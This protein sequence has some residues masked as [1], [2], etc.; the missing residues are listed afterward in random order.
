MSVE[1][2]H[3]SPIPAR[4]T[5][6]GSVP[7]PILVVVTLLGIEGLGNLLSIP[8]NT[9]AAVW[10]A[11]KGLFIVGLLK[12]WRP[13][14]FLFLVIAVLHVIGFAPLAPII[15]LMNLVLMLLVVVSYR[16]Y[17]PQRGGD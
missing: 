4:E 12:R 13:V 6:R 3:A 8:S 7:W 11:F 1:S 10:L 17:F 14:F 5:T 2:S 9:T 16:F 15:A